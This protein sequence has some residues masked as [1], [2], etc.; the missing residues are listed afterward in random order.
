MEQMPLNSP[1]K[2]PR[3]NQCYLC[4]EWHLEKNLSSIEVPD[5]AGWVEKKACEKCLKGIVGE[6]KTD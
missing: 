1:V 2:Y 5:Q 3:L 4:K 6:E